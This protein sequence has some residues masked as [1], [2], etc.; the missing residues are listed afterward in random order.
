MFEFERHVP[1]GQYEF[2]FKIRL[3]TKI[4][5]SFKTVFNNREIYEIRYEL[6]IYFNDPEPILFCSKEIKIVKTIRAADGMKRK[7][8]SLIYEAKKGIITEEEDINFE[9]AA[10]PVIDKLE[11]TS[12][13]VK[14]KKKFNFQK[15][16]SSGEVLHKQQPHKG[17]NTSVDYLTESDKKKA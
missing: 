9:D 13:I 5:T 7:V 11:M 6:K 14:G 2:P 4:P 8:G 12:S 16:K 15:L 17:I 3:P 10:T 1:I